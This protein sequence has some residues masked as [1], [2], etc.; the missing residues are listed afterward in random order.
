ML[1]IEGTKVNDHLKTCD[2]SAAVVVVQLVEPF[3]LTFIVYTNLYCK[4]QIKFK[5][6]W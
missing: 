4:I 2:I 1:C 5:R 6:G 3:L